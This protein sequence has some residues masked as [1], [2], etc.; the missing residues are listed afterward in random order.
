MERDYELFYIVRP[1]VEEEQVRTT[2]DELAAML[3][4][5]GGTINK[6]S[7]WGRRR[8]AYEIDGF[9]DGYYALKELRYPSEKVRDL[10]RTLRL[11]ERVI[12][13]LIT[14]KQVYFLPGDGDDRKSRRA[15]PRARPAGEGAEASASGAPAD[16]TEERP[17]AGQEPEAWGADE[18][19]QE[20]REE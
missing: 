2:M 15:R 3:T 20:V 11:D 5:R 14:L 9:S 16:E 12:R 13:H 10:E 6:S 1:D 19:S 7:L 4:E 18:P 17:Q 8:L